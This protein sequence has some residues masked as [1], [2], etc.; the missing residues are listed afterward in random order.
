MDEPGTTLTSPG[1]NDVKVFVPAKDFERSLSFYTSLGWHM[2]WSHAD[3]LAEIELA[4][5]RLYLQNY[6]AREWAENFMIYVPV[7]DARA[8][9]QHVQ[10]VLAGGEFPGARVDPPRE[11]DYGAVVTYAWDPSGVLLHFAQSQATR[12]S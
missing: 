9:H 11:E 4:G 3:G 1:A 12:A 7:D 5:V 8:W 10:A 2:N 6:Y